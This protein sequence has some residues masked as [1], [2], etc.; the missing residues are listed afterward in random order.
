MNDTKIRTVPKY[1]TP[2]LPHVSLPFPGR[3]GRSQSHDPLGRAMAIHIC[4]H[5]HE[6]DPALFARGCC[7]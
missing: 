5:Y 6:R 4:P 1:R 2:V 3:R 7:Y